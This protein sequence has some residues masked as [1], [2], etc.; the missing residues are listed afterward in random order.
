MNGLDVVERVPRSLHR[1]AIQD[2][3]CR[4]AKLDILAKEKNTVDIFQY[5]IK[6]H[7]NLDIAPTTAYPAIN[8]P[9]HDIEAP[10]AKPSLLGSATTLAERLVPQ[11]VPQVRTQAWLRLGYPIPPPPPG[12]N[13]PNNSHAAP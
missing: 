7:V 10:T 5:T 11:H 13:I 12:E 4:E 1:H 6:H 8:K 9:H 3:Q 2:S